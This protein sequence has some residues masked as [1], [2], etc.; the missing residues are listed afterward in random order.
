M[1]KKGLDSMEI[2]V[3]QE[4]DQTI[5][6]METEKAGV[7]YGKCEGCQKQGGENN[8][9]SL[10]SHSFIQVKQPSLNDDGSW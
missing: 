9:F 1:V 2:L 8:E 10:P 4:C 7:L 5:E 6:Y 3:C